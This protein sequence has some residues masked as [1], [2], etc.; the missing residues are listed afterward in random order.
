MKF[1]FKKRGGQVLIESIIAISVATVGL[2]GILT[3]LSRSISFN[4]YVTDSFVATY[5]SAEGIEV[6]KNIEDTN[7]TN[8]DQW[9][10]YLD[11]GSY[12]VQYDTS[13]TSLDP[14]RGLISISSDPAVLSARP[15]NFNPL[16]GI[17][18]YDATS[19]QPTIFS[20]TVQITGPGANN[21]EIKVVSV[22][23]WN[24]KGDEKQVT[25]EDHFFDWRP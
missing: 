21:D 2:L 9:N 24:D 14:S 11:Q 15:L 19:S 22:V 1:N 5:L 17:Y 25:L 23:R 8:H 3:L 4:R 7:N 6:V 12:E 20:R 16:N 10:R 18:G 13:P